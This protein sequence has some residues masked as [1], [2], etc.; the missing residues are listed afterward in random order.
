[1]NLKIFSSLH[2]NSKAITA[3]SLSVFSGKKV[4]MEKLFGD[5]FPLESKSKA[6]PGV[7]GKFAVH[8][9]LR[10]FFY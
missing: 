9:V 4:L 8:Q 7:T 6:A 10:I 5:I 1:M 3:N 2:P